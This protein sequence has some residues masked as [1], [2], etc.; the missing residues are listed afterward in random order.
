MGTILR[1]RPPAREPGQAAE[2]RAASAADVV[3]FPGVR[4]ERH[5]IDLAFR[6]SEPAS[7]GKDG[8]IDN[9]RPRRSS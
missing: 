9:A 7:T 4:I 5:G 6:L 3:I 1:F 8:N 2:L